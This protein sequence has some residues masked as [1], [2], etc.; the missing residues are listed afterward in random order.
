MLFRTPASG[1]FSVSPRPVSVFKH[2]MVCIH[3]VGVHQLY[4]KAAVERASLCP[5]WKNESL[6]VHTSTFIA[7]I[8]SFIVENDFNSTLVREFLHL[9]FSDLI[10]SAFSSSGFINVAAESK[11]I[12]L[13]NDLFVPVNVPQTWPWHSVYRS[14]S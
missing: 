13:L 7:L 2:A 5:T 10:S 14:L 8:C 9:M 1:V 12:T 3:T 4:W 6:N 11:Q